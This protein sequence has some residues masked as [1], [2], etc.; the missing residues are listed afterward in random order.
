MCCPFILWM[1][2]IGIRPSVPMLKGLG[3]QW[4]LG[5]QVLPSQTYT[6]WKGIKKQPLPLKW[7]SNTGWQGTVVQPVVR[8]LSQQSEEAPLDLNTTYSVHQRKRGRL[9][10]S[11]MGST[12]SILARECGSQPSGCFAHSW[13]RPA[14]SG[15][16]SLPMF[17]QQQLIW[18]V[19]AHFLDNKPALP[20]T[21]LICQNMLRSMNIIHSI[22]T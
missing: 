11:Q 21:L 16:A 12:L 17:N 20:R 4:C 7:R 19:S 1:F 3:D 13:G 9:S 6:Y 10:P 14:R 5:I 22:T 18:A 2:G 8:C 15:A